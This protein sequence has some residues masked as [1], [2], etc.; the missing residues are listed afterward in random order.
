[1]KPGMKADFNVTRAQKQIAISVEIGKRP[2]L[3]RKR[4]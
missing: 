4:Q 2:K 1:L 3:A